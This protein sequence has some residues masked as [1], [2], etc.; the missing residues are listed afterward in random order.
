MER[1]ESSHSGG[2]LKGKSSFH[3]SQV[4][5]RVSL[6]VASVHLSIR[7]SYTALVLDKASSPYLLS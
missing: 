2:V 6:K 7:T 5:E 3:P 1:M 4:T